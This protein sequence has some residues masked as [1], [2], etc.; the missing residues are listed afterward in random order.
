MPAITVP[1]ITVLP[2]VIAAPT[3][4]SRGVRQVTT[5][6]QGY[7]GE[8]FPVRRAFAGVDLADLDPFIHLDIGHSQITLATTEDGGTLLRLI[9]GTLG[10]LDGP[11]VTHTPITMVHA[12]IAPGAQMNIPWRSDF[13]ALAYVLS[14]S[15]AAGASKQPI[16]TGQ[17]AL[18]GDGDS[19]LISAH[20]SQDARHAQGLDVLILGGQ[21][22][23]EPIAWA[24]PFVMNTRL[25][26]MAAFEE[27]SKGAFGQKRYVHGAPESVQES[28]IGR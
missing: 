3:L 17:L 12:T 16:T 21:S 11:G 28:N 2:R 5:A 13:N 27:F 7:E 20:E 9:A 6:P 15:G 14:G 10:E 4:R 8:G 26:V 19:L 1:D 18:F 22:I 23:R 24:G 25:E